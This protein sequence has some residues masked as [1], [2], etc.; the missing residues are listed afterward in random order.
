MFI[1]IVALRPKTYLCHTTSMFILSNV[2]E[3][4]FLHDR[5]EWQMSL[6]LI[7]CATDN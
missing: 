2:N 1:D 7:G 3:C 4:C 6:R 5:A